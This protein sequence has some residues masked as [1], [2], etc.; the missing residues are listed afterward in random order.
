MG[1][2]TWPGPLTVGCGWLRKPLLAA[3]GQP[4]RNTQW[5]WTQE[6]KR[7]LFS[8]QHHTFPRQPLQFSLRGMYGDTS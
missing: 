4:Q 1:T 5:V 6:G 3:G 2:W 8:P 7:D